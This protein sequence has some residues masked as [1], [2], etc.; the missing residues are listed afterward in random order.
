MIS[1]FST[2]TKLSRQS[3]FHRVAAEAPAWVFAGIESHHMKVNV[4]GPEFPLNETW[5][6]R[7]PWF[8]HLL[9]YVSVKDKVEDPWNPNIPIV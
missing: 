4:S 1:K 8:R 2:P 7:L 5:H 6:I 3:H 9:L